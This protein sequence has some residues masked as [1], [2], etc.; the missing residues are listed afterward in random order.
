MR[1]RRYP[2]D[3]TAAEWALIEPLLPVPACQTERGGRPEKHPRR[4]IVDAIRYVVDNGI[5]WRAIPHDYGVPW[6]TVYGFFARWARTGVVAC[7]RDQ[8]RARLRTH[9][10]YA[11]NPV[12]IVLDS[13][14]VRA[15]ETASKA[16]RGYDAAKKVNGP[17]RHLAVDLGGWPVM[18]MVT[19]AARTDRDAARELLTRL[20]LTHPELACAWADR[21]YAGTQVTW[22]A[23]F[24]NLTLAIVSRPPR[25]RGFVVVP[26]RWVVER[27]LSWIM[28]A[29]RNVRDYE[30]LPQHSEAHLTWATITLM[31]RNLTREQPQPAQR[32]THL[33]PTGK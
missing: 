13:Q 8:L 2:S 5:K 30:R 32:G 27:T 11:P 10:D 33:A 16:T 23:S 21:A 25:S 14:T 1:R 24:L 29:R 12:A 31:T 9:R 26:R 17:K 15:A 7:I 19:P 4:A 20:R 6:Q 3:T 22:A 18:V 28:Q